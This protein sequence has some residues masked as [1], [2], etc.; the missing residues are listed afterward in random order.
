[1]N[2]SHPLIWKRIRLTSFELFKTTSF[3]TTFILTSFA[4]RNDV[5]LLF[6]T[7][8]PSL[9]LSL[10]VSLCQ[11]FCLPPTKQ[12]LS[13]FNRL[14]ALFTQF[15]T[16][17]CFCFSFPIYRC[18]RWEWVTRPLFKNKIEVAETTPKSL[19]GGRFARGLVRPPPTKRA[20]GGQT[21]P[22]AL[23]GGRPPQG[24]NP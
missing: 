18:A 11:E 12:L 7:R 20:G 5:N 15:F 17:Y 13:I 19:G 6:I 24:S 23:G 1:V 10:C 2:Y 9:S 22:M 8:S 14:G 4:V 3:K 16:Q 21:K